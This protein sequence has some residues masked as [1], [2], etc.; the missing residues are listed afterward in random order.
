MQSRQSALQHPASGPPQNFADRSALGRSTIDTASPRVSRATRLHWGICGPHVRSAEVYVQV[1]P[2]HKLRGQSKQSQSHIQYTRASLRVAAPERRGSLFFLTALHPLSVVCR[3]PPN[4]SPSDRW[5]WYAWEAGKFPTP[6]AVA[7]VA[8]VHPSAA[9]CSCTHHQR[10]RTPTLDL[11]VACSTA[12]C[13]HS[14]QIVCLSRSHKTTH[15]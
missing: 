8:L 10:S 2:W 4:P 12:P 3:W 6:P 9:G 1:V 15:P 13:L 7:N 14:S 5:F 11:H